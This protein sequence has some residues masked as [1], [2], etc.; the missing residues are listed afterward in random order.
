MVI[1]LPL[2]PDTL[3]EQ[4]T[5]E[6]NRSCPEERFFASIVCDFET[7]QIL[8]VHLGFTLEET[9]EFVAYSPRSLS[10]QV[11]KMLTT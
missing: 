4:L 8:G 11:L 3:L 1:F 2:F 10:A 7:V 5:E 6:Q 9:E